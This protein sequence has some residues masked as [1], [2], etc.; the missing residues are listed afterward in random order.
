M[1]W[2]R[3]YIVSHF[4]YVT[5]CIFLWLTETHILREAPSSENG[6]LFISEFIFSFRVPIASMR[7]MRLNGECLSAVPTPKNVLNAKTWI[8]VLSTC[9]QAVNDKWRN[10]ELIFLESNLRPASSIISSNHQ[11][12]RF[13]SVTDL[14]Y[15]TSGF[16]ITAIRMSVVDYILEYK[17]NCLSYATHSSSDIHLCFVSI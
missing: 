7:K 13:H 17:H 14:R 8:V 1:E 11:I 4:I 12:Y 6:S 16:V 2:G 15:F 10:S 3:F 9:L 5:N